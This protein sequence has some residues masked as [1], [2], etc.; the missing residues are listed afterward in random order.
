M[1]TRCQLLGRS[2]TQRSAAARKSASATP[3]SL[4]PITVPHLSIL[5]IP[6]NATLLKLYLLRGP[7][8]LPETLHS[9]GWGPRVDTGA[10]RVSK[11]VRKLLAMAKRSAH[12]TRSVTGQQ[13]S[14]TAHALRTSGRQL[15]PRTPVMLINHSHLNTL[16]NL[17]TIQPHTIV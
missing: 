2:A 7:H 12:V 5:P 3:A 11:T 14:T 15:S 6:I 8:S 10:L 17:A 4:I 9:M 13:A 1:L 16:T